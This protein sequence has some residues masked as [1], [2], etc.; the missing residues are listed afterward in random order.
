MSRKNN[1]GSGIGAIIAF[2]IIVYFGIISPLQSSKDTK[3]NN[4]S[5]VNSSYTHSTYKSTNSNDYYTGTNNYK[6]YN[7]YEDE[8][9]ETVYITDTGSKYH[10]SGCQYLRSSRHAISK[11]NAISNGYGACSRCHP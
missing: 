2:I 8:D 3:D 7:N 9:S 11:S 4:I 5:N 6:D 1:D 10:R